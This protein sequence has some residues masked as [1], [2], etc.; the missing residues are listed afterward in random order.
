MVIV[1]RGHSVYAVYL[2]H[3]VKYLNKATGIL[4]NSTSKISK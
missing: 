4:Q 3:N 2:I 1:F